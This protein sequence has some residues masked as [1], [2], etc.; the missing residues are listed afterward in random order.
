MTPVM[1]STARND[2]DYADAVP[3]FEFLVNRN[4]HVIAHEDV[5]IGGEEQ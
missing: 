2:S 5:D 3:F 4:R 1:R